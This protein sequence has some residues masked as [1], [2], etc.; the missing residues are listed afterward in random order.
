M[1]NEPWFNLDSQSARLYQEA[2]KAE[3]ST[4]EPAYKEPED[5]YFG[6]DETAPCQSSDDDFNGDDQ[7]IRFGNNRKHV[8]KSDAKAKRKAAKKSKQRNRK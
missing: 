7:P 1:N 3:Q 5:D 2:Q 8:K 4:S 6:E